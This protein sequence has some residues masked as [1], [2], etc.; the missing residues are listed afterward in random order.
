MLWAPFK[1][2]QKGSHVS[3]SGKRRCISAVWKGK[4]AIDAA[5]PP[6]RHPI[7]AVWKERD[8]FVKKQ[9]KEK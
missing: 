3:S 9:K 2:W 5:C 8:I 6:P 4:M 7:F 1:W